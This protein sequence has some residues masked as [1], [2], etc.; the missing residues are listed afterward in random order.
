MEELLSELRDARQMVLGRFVV[1]LGAPVS[2]A[3]LVASAIESARPWAG[4]RRLVADCAADLPLVSVDER[5]LRRVFANLIGNAVKFTERDGVI[6][7]GAEPGPSPNRVTFFVRDDGQGIPEADQAH[8][9][10][11][12]WQAAPRPRHG[13]GLGLTIC[14]GI[15][16]AHRGRITVTSRLGAGSTFAFTLPCAGRQATPAAY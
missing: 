10:E 16:E 8:I 3:Q 11:P 9:F 2:P 15:V 1:A 5:R 13:S 7:V 12:Y 4:D 14:K 6:T